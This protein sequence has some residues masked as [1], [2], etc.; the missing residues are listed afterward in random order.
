VNLEELIRSAQEEQAARAVPPSRVLA[1]LSGRVVTRHRRRRWALAAAVTA[2]AVATVVLIVAVPVVLSH[3]PA[4]PALPVAAPPSS[5][6]PTRDPVHIIALGYRPTWMPSG[7]TERIRQFTPADPGDEY[8]PTLMRVWRRQ[9]GAGD[10]F[11]ADAEVTLYVRTAVADASAAIDRS[12]DRVSVNGH[13]GHYSGTPGEH[14]SSLDWALGPHTVLMLAADHM[15]LSRT[16]MLRIARSVQPDTGVFPVPFQLPWL[17]PGQP[18]AA[19]TI[20]GPSTERWRAELSTDGLTVIAGSTAEAPAG[21]A[22]LTVGGHP[23]RHP[24]RHDAAGRDFNYLVVDLGRSRYLT[25]LSPGAVPFNDL[26]KIAA[27]ARML[28]TGLDWLG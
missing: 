13:D 23:A 16:D 1:A 26:V 7:Y 19:V 28:P 6:P 4:A 14:K 20:S 18:A 5:A 11:T 15:A 25:L 10:P 2:A 3:R 8:G 17:P 12:G 27:T 22:T 21:G 9:V 24:V